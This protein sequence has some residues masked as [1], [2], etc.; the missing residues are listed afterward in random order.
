MRTRTTHTHTHTLFVCTM[1]KI[2]RPRSL[3]GGWSDRVPSLAKGPTRFPQRPQLSEKLHDERAISIESS[4]CPTKEANLHPS[5]P[6]A[7]AMLCTEWRLGATKHACVGSTAHVLQPLHPTPARSPP[8]LRKGAGLHEEGGAR[9][10]CT[11]LPVRRP[12]ARA[13]ARP[14][15]LPGAIASWTRCDDGSRPEAT[16]I[17]S[18][19]AT[20]QR[21]AGGAT[22]PMQPPEAQ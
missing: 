4:D 17:Y 20:C 21:T 2:C 22:V 10:S 19:E 11:G 3:H 8:Q 12:R 18:L 14:P 1:R 9:E 5:P 16:L 15:A 13:L 7:E 6:A